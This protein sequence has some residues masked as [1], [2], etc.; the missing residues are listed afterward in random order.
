MLTNNIIDLKRPAFRIPGKLAKKRGRKAGDP[1]LMAAWLLPQR[2]IWAVFGRRRRRVIRKVGFFLICGILA[3]SSVV[4][5]W[6]D[7]THIAMGM[8]V[9]GSEENFRE[10]EKRGEFTAYYDLAAPDLA[11][12]RASNEACNHYYNKARDEIVTPALVA[13][14]VTQ[15]GKV[16]ANADK[17][18]LYGAIVDSLRKYV[19]IRFKG[20][21]ADYYMAYAGHYVGDLVMPLHN[22]EFGGIVHH[23][24]NDAVVEHEISITTF[25]QPQIMAHMQDYTLNS[26]A[27]VMEKIAELAN[28]TATLGYQLVDEGKRTMTPEEAY[29]QLGAGASL[30]RAINA[31]AQS[32]VQ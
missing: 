9:Y 27:E 2:S 6:H 28:R 29:T 20:G 22:V 3:F 32:R 18:H 23:G 30:F 12:L 31:Y 8:A 4:N 21:F 26:E 24:A 16:C 7:K 13:Q 1:G 10:A 25:N 14:Q 19:E 17:G 5:A 15:A 11:K